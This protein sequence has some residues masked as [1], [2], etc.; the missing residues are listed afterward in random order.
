MW[1]FY[2]QRGIGRKCEACYEFCNDPMK[3]IH[4]NDKIRM[5]VDNRIKML[6]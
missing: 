2:A 4:F 3:I 5:K 6:K 1:E